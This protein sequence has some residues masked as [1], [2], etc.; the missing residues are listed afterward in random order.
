VRAAAIAQGTALTDPL[1]RDLFERFLPDDQRR[2]V[3]G[4]AFDRAA[5]LARSGDATR[6]RAVF[7]TV[8]VACHRLGDTGSE[9][10]PDL[11]HVGTKWDRAGL[12]EQIV[13]P[14]AVVAD[15]WRLTTIE[16]KSGDSRSGFITAHDGEGVTLRLAGGLTE[17]IPR[18]QIAKRRASRISAMPEGLLQTL[19][20]PEAA[21]LLEFLTR[22]K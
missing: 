12:L 8:C 21:D 5:L 9:F 13:A 6:G 3:L 15:A 20:A 19:T 16:L 22:L 7:A 10:G 18:A 4:A 1:R 14:S 11:A 2:R 17:K